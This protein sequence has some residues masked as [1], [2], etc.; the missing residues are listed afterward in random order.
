MSFL[1]IAH[2]FKLANVIRL[3]APHPFKHRNVVCLFLPDLLETLDVLI[4]PLDLILEHSYVFLQ[5]LVDFALSLHF[6][7]NSP[8][9]FQLDQVWPQAFSLVL[10]GNFS[11]SGCRLAVVFLVGGRLLHI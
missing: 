1:V 2:L 8:Q 11:G 3:V 6:S 9:V 4:S 10:L 7:L 5:T